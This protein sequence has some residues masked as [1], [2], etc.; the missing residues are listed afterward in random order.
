MKLGT[1]V[2]GERRGKGR[3]GRGG[4]GKEGEG[5]R[6]EQFTGKYKDYGVVSSATA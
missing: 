2:Q 5:R 4:K 1:E 6:R 3:R